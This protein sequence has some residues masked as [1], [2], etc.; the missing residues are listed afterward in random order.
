MSNLLADPEWISTFRQLVVELLSAARDLERFPEMPSYHNTILSS[1]WRPYHKKLATHLWRAADASAK[2]S[3][4][5]AVDK[6]LWEA[7]QLAWAM[8]DDIA[9]KSQ[10]NPDVTPNLTNPDVTSNLIMALKRVKKLLAR[11]RAAIAPPSNRT[12][13]QSEKQQ[14]PSL[15]VENEPPD[16]MKGP[17]DKVIVCG[18]E[19]DPLTPAQYR[20]VKVLVEAKAENKRLSIQSIQQRTKDESENVVEDPLGV[21]KRLRKDPDWAK[22]I[23]MAGRWGRGYGL[24][25]C[26]PRTTRKNPVSHPRR[27]R[28]G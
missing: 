22:V 19:K 26:P 5:G 27:P 6:D 4:S 8:M 16:V 11:S 23:D 7:Y 9:T 17:D 13:A 12:D 2:G 3:G 15:P 21:L 24:C 20:V 28:G 10:A 25:N 1:R 14:P 18:K